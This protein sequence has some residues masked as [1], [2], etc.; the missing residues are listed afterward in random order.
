[1]HSDILFKTI[2]SS[3]TYVEFNYG[4]ANL[5]NLI[6]SKNAFICLFSGRRQTILGNFKEDKF[7]EPILVDKNWN[8]IANE[9]G[10]WNKNPKKKKKFDFL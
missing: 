4:Y 7:L 5:E 10:N 1:M 6:I 3:N 2:Y 9:L 8:S